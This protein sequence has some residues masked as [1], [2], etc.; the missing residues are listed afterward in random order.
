MPVMT[1][2]QQG[3]RG[4]AI[5]ISLHHRT[6]DCLP[7]ADQEAQEVVKNVRSGAQIHQRGPR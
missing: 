2:T 6:A 4:V 1:D 3:W 7:Q 5:F